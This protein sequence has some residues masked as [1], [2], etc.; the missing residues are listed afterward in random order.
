MTQTKTGSLAEAG[1][2]IAVGFAINWTANMLV[3]PL[4]GF[5]GLTAGK[6]FGIGLVFTVISL[7]RSYIL[8][9]WFN[10]LKFG[11]A[12]ASHGR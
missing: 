5:T 7:V 4:F 1:A 6:A 8:R 12:E 3:L 9:R 11:N 2:N 10:G